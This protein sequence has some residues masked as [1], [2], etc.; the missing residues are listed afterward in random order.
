M[1]ACIT[2]K[3]FQD[4]YTRFQNTYTKADG[5]VIVMYYQENKIVHV[6]MNFSN[7]CWATKI[8]VEMAQKYLSM[9]PNPIPLQ[10]SY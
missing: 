7:V 4:L 6:Y 8:E 5:P 1:K 10:S 2:S 9:F 3:Q